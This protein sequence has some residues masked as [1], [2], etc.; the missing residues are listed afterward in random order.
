MGLRMFL[1]TSLTW[2]DIEMP[3][4]RLSEGEQAAVGDLLA[5]AESGQTAVTRFESL[6]VE[7]EKCRDVC[8]V[9][10]QIACAN[11]LSLSDFPAT[12]TELHMEKGPDGK[13]TGKIAVNQAL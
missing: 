11:V 13:W 10:A 2:P 1:K 9:Q 12:V 6:R 3:E 4:Y 5:R 8:F 7:S